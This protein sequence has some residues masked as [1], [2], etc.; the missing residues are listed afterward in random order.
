[1]PSL[2]NMQPI[3][4]FT[5]LG[6]RN[7]HKPLYLCLKVDGSLLANIATVFLRNVARNGIDVPNDLCR[8]F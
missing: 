3:E 1:V 4:Q 6:H 7:I 8:C 5:K 2:V